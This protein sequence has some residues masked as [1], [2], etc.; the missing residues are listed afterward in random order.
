M[1]ISKKIQAIAKTMD[2]SLETDGNAPL[3]KSTPTE[4][5]DHGEVELAPI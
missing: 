5:T 1:V 3:L 2:F 4:L